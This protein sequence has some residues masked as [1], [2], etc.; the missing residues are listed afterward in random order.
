MTKHTWATPDHQAQEKGQGGLEIGM[1][2]D[3]HYL[4]SAKMCSFHKCSKLCDTM[5]L[6]R[7]LGREESVQV[8]SMKSCG[9]RCGPSASGWRGRGLLA[10]KPRY[11]TPSSPTPRSEYTDTL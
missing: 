11:P 5:R 1:G 10:L 6:P 3:M 2:R 8:A 7:D 9:H 4:L